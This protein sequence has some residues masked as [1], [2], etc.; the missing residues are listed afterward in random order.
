MIFDINAWVGTWPFRTLADGTPE[1]L[2]AKMDDAGIDRSAVSLLEAVFH[3]N[4]QP[5][6]ERLA[7]MIAP[8][9]DRLT[10]LATLNPTYEKWEDDLRIC[11]EKLGMKGVRLF[12]VYHDYPVDGPAA[13]AIAAAC[14][15]RKLPVMLPFRMEDPR[16]RHWLDPGRTVDLNGAA[17]LL[18]ATPD[19]TLVITNYRGLT[20]VPMWRREEL[21]DRQWYVDTSLAEFHRDLEEFVKQGSAGHLV[22]G[23][24]MPF[25][26]AASALVKRAQLPVDAGEL[27]E[28]DSGR[29][30]RLFGVV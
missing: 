25:S 1:G 20:N 27:A 8:H 19:L 6:N 5:A 12:P 18:A 30:T 14:A 13:R 26:Y 28:I 2:I 3:R 22:F 24:H 11:H 21:R 17:N 15:E 16:Q 23:T 29:A 7:G 9:R 10:P 4:V